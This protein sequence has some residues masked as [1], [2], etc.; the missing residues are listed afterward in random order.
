MNFK[1]IIRWTLVGVLAAA[2][3]WLCFGADGPASP[4][5]A[6]AP[7]PP[8][9]LVVR[10]NFFVSADS[11]QLNYKGEVLTL[12]L[13][14]SKA[15][16]GPYVLEKSPQAGWSQ[17]RTYRELGQG[18]LDVIS[19]MTNQTREAISIP[20]RYCLYKG[21]LGV[22]IGMG[23][24]TSVRKFNAIT[25]WDALTQV[26]FGLVF[27]WP[28]YAI[29][30]DAGLKV[31]RLPA[32]E[33]SIVRVKRGTFDLLPMGIVEVGALAKKHD[34][35][36]ISTWAIAYPTAYYFFVSKT[37]PE[38]AQRLEYGFEQAL[39]DQSFEHLFAKRIGPLLADASLENRQIF[40]LKNPYLPKETPL[41]RK[42]LWHPLV[43]Q[44]LQETQGKL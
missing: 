32:L 37:R 26:N 12:L 15:R 29:Q 28:D 18:H 44:Q 16:F 24:K 5:T 9:P 11:D 30:T 2:S 42:E 41:Q 3:P 33:S 19:S 6:S 43:L 10:H 21:L 27:D 31:L 13:E 25:T 4:P 7:M 8:T 34:L 14:K 20:I 22:R 40:Y 36:T 17:N 23:S 39:K 35:A 1:K 38:L